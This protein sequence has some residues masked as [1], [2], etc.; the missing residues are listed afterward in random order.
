M[1]H[2]GVMRTRGVTW[3]GGAAWVGV[4]GRGC[5]GGGSALAAAEWASICAGA[6][7]WWWGTS[8]SCTLLLSALSVFNN[9]WGQEKVR[10][11]RAHGSGMLVWG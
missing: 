3:A 6:Q 11:H 1:R 7:C 9:Q 2:V 5:A 4:E 8:T 10:S